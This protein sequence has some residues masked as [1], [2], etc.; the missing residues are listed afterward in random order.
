MSEPAST[1]RDSDRGHAGPPPI[2][3]ELCDR[4]SEPLIYFLIIFCPWAFGTTPNWAMHVANTVGDTLGLLLLTKWIIRWR[5]AFQPMR[6]GPRSYRPADLA[7]YRTRWITRLVAFTTIGLLAQCFISA[8]NARATY[9]YASG[10]FAYHNCISWLPH[11]YDSASTWE[12]FWN[13]LAWAAAF[14]ALRDWLLGKSEAEVLSGLRA[15]REQGAGGTAHRPTAG[16]PIRL[17]RLL[18]VLS[19]NGAALSLEAIIQL[20]SGTNKLLWL[21]PTYYNRAAE[22]Q[23]GPFPYR[24]NGAQYVNLVWPVTLGFWWALQRARPRVAGTWHHLLLA[25]IAIMIAGPAMTL[26]RGGVLVA[27]ANVLVGGA[28]LL[29]SGRRIHSLRSRLAILVLLL[30]A[31]AGGLYGVWD[32]LDVRMKELAEG[33]RGRERMTEVG[34]RMAADA[35]WFGTGAETLQPLYQLYKG[36]AD[37]YWP[38]Q[39][40]NDW[41]ETRITFGLAGFGLILCGL[42]M[43]LARWRVG[44]GI[45]VSWRFV[46]FIWLA[47]AGCLVHA[48][49]DLPFQ[50]YSITLL[51][52][53]YCSVLLCLGEK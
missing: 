52:L 34:R 28:L 45:P 31:L 18:W 17:Q 29:F 2:G 44:G 11:S 27:A 49:W 46:S 39:L 43:A 24:S 22:A 12:A 9:F 5:T 23:F 15:S 26:S 53:L 6:W 38:G 8:C 41:L 4:A 40:H 7:A 36:P 35:P 25:C 33:F 13:Y 20:T 32:R 47:M 16:L 37:E 19:F 30:V 51:L 1:V 48:R 21:Q 3:Y 10:T 14:W 42:A 50:V